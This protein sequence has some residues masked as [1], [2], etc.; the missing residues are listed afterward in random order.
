MLVANPDYYE[1]RPYIGRVVYRVIPSQ[2]TIF[3]E[4]KAKGVD[5][6]RT[7]TG[8]PVRA[9]DGLPGVPQG[10]QQVSGIL[11]AATR[12]LGFNLK[13]PRFADRRVRRA[14]AH[15][16]N[17]HEL[18]DGVV[19]GLGPR[20]HRAA[21]ARDVGVHRRRAS[22]T[23]TIR[24]RPRRS[25][26]RRGGRTATATGSSRTRTASRFAFTILTNQ[27]NDERKKVAEI[28]QQRLK[29]DV[30]V[31]G[32]HPGHRVGGASSRSYV[33]PRQF[34][35]VI[36]GTGDGRRPDQYVVWHSS[37]TGPDQMNRTGYANP[38]VD[39][40][41]GGRALLVRPGKSA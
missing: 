11:R 39:R 38:E 14:F 7:L 32:R 37:Q 30:G 29:R 36:L 24:R 10:V 33:K 3:L 34:D 41:A 15:A 35:A 18:I 1:G 6:V 26:P 27:G 17:K 25:W 12:F 13:D 4:L 40:L 8:V 9:P 23:T 16:I 28:I 5:Y 21:S 2:A 22:A 20:G 19:L 31:D